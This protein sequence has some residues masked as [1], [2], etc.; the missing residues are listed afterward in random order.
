VV[1][2]VLFMFELIGRNFTIR[3]DYLL[4]GVLSLFMVGLNLAIYYLLNE[5]NDQNFPPLPMILVPMSSLPGYFVKRLC[6]SS[7][8]NVPFPYFLMLLSIFCVSVSK[9]TSRIISLIVSLHLLWTIALWYQ[10][11][12]GLC[13]EDCWT[14]QSSRMVNAVA[15][16]CSN[17][18]YLQIYGSN[19]VFDNNELGSLFWKIAIA[20]Q[21]SK[22]EM[23]LPFLADFDLAQSYKI[24]T[25][26]QLKELSE[27]ASKVLKD[28]QSHQ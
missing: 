18:I 9:P 8:A 2:A 7:Q 28:D 17:F 24:R 13:D 23:K 14:Y 26:E 6:V 5:L 22:Q 4:L 10:V 16:L 15:C 19:F 25:K 1:V 20:L 3:N 27:L 21:R 12:S 11:W